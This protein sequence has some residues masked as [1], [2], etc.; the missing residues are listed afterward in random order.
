MPQTPFRLPRRQFMLGSAAAAASG[1]LSLAGCQPVLSQSLDHVSGGFV[2]QHPERGH[3]LRDATARSPV[4]NPSPTAGAAPDTLRRVHTLI[5][6]GGV[7]GLAA[8]RALNLAGH[9]DYALLELEDEAGGNARA[10]ALGGLACPMGAH[11][12]PVPGN[13]NPH[14][15]HLLEDLGV[16]QRVAGRWVYDERHL[17]HSPQERLYLNGHWQAG[18]LPA[19]GITPDTLAQYRRFAA[20]VAQAQRSSRYQIPA[21]FFEKN[22]YLPPDQ[23]ALDALFFDDWLTRQ[24]LT[25]PHLRWYLD[26]CCRDDYGA[27]IATVSAWAGVHY[28]AGRH[29]FHVPGDAPADASAP[30]AGGGATDG[31]EGFESVLTWPEG[32]AWLTRRMAQPLG[33]RLHT[34]CVVQRID[35]TRHGV[36][37]LALD[38][39]SGQPQRWLAQR[40][41]VA[42]PVFVAAR[43]VVNPPPALQAAAS[44]LRYAPWVV[45]NL[46]LSR[47]L[48]DRGGAAPAWDSVVYGTAGL[49]YVD[50]THQALH[51]APGTPT[52]LTHYRALGDVSAGRAQLL[53]QPWQHWVQAAVAEL[54]PAHPELASRLTQASVARYGHAMAMPTPGLLSRLVPLHQAI[55]HNRPSNANRMLFAHS[56]W[57][58]Y[59]VLEEAF[60]MG[61]AAGQLAAG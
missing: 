16:R 30:G 32:N 5:A 12:L 50:A 4:A 58:G 20:L 23:Q 18:L 31:G 38:T 6:G 37:V 15:Q 41:I 43:V 26:Y 24:G 25:D 46:H 22:R 1:A 48:A 44:H 27:G 14:L 11:Y 33:D 61:L 2:G 45:T 47:P 19:D 51:T 35:A 52:V 8:A 9:D 54:T 10:T 34:G 42:L 55:L 59:S 28:F 36:E 21:V 57:A 13:H 56:D 29:G 49:G 39:R 7:A 53:A 17:C 3:A 60:A 40:C